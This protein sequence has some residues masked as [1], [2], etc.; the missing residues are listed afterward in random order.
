VMPQITVPGRRTPSLGM[1]MISSQ[2]LPSE[3]TP[4][5]T[6][7]VPQRPS[8]SACSRLSAKVYEVDSRIC[9]RYGSEMKLI[10]VIT[11]PSEVSKILPATSSR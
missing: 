9:P 10:A 5:Q 3:L 4:D 6:R 8:R 11:D 1:T 7:T 2:G